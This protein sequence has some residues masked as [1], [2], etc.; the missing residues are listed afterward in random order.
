[1]RLTTADRDRGDRQAVPPERE[2]DHGDDRTDHE[3]PELLN[4]PNDRV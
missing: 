1:M 3:G 4:R 2:G